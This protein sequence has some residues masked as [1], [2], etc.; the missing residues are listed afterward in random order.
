MEIYGFYSTVSG[1]SRSVGSRSYGKSWKIFLIFTLCL[2]AQT[3]WLAYR[4][5]AFQRRD[6]AKR[7]EQKSIETLQPAYRSKF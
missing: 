4:D 5:P 1:I 3:G 7:D 6:L 2:H